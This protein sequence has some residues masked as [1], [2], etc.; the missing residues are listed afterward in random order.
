MKDMVIRLARLAGWL[1][2]IW[3]LAKWIVASVNGVTGSPYLSWPAAA[4]FVIAALLAGRP[5]MARG[6]DRRGWRIRA[7]AK[8]KRKTRLARMVPWRLVR[9]TLPGKRFAFFRTL[10]LTIAMTVVFGAASIPYVRARIA[11]GLPKDLSALLKYNPP[12]TTRVYSADNELICTFTNENRVRVPLTDVPK[13]VQQAFIAA[14]DR[15]FYSHG[16]IDPVSIVRAATVNYRSGA[17]RQG[18]STLTQQVV[19]Q[20]VLHDN[21][22]TI[23]RKIREIVLAVDVEHLMTKDEILEVYLNHVF[24]GHNAYGV[25]A[26]AQAY[27][28]KDVKDLTL[29]EAAM[30]A[31]LPRAPSHDSP[32]SHYDRAR[33]RQAYVLG[34]MVN[35]GFVTQAQADAALH[36]EIAIIY[37]E[38]ALNHT[39]APYFCDHVRRELK[40]MFGNEAIFEKGLT[41]Q[42]TLDMRMQ[43]AAESA[44]RR[45]LIDL[46]RR[47]GFNGPE[48]KDPKYAGCTGPAEGIVDGVIDMAR[49]AGVGGTPSVCVKGTVYPIYAEDAD[50]IATW[51][52]SSSKKL[53]VGDLMSVQIAT[54]APD[55]VSKGATDKV[56]APVVAPASAKR[57]AIS[58]RRTSGPG[59]PDALQAALIATDPHTGELK[60]YV[61]GYDFV[62]S[63][64]DAASMA[65]RQPGSSIKPY[66]YLTALAHGLKVD[67]VVIDAPFCYPSASGIWCPQNYKSPFGGDQYYGRIGLR[68]ALALSLNS[69]S[70]QLANRVG[71]E[72]VIRTMRALGITS[73]LPRVLPLAIGAAELTPWEHTFA[74]TSLAAGGKKLPRHPGSEDAGI[75]IR[76]VVDASGKDLYRYVPVPREQWPQAVNAGDAYCMTYLM[77]GVVEQGTGHRVQELQR[78]AAA[79]TGTTNDFRDTWF[80]GFT[81]DLVVGVWVGRMTPQP[82]VKEATGGSVALP[83]W[84]AAVKEMHPHTPP[85]DFSVPD[86][87]MLVHS[88]WE[89]DMI[90]YQRGRLPY[91]LLGGS[92]NTGDLK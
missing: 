82:I 85:R 34:Q 83:I 71:I 47:I 75:F 28:G 58:A 68:R 67:D 26:A 56:G 22:K 79:K 62:E 48:G 50:R 40:R 54:I 55:P 80:M 86:D 60:A 69:V 31:G 32:F 41:V 11:E 42:T 90:P 38:D 20:V 37:R 14:E 13:H 74:Y 36:E 70:V 35:A 87:V 59:H 33:V 46:E 45:G 29:G 63:Q 61:G 89:A 57:Y 12:V 5:Y 39:A 18:A 17:T 65:H 91:Q 7:M 51:E 44:V 43:R 88:V 8:V 6:V 78:P 30:L 24:L 3:L 72:E 1:L 10:A 76:S 92:G 9:V 21:A 81:N 23:A 77:K 66:V 49:V 19:K 16:G 2:A 25:Q 53:A 52:K 64:F 27:F 4:L 73:P 84:L 15:D